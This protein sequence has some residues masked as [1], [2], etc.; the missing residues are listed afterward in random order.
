MNNEKTF[1]DIVD[2]TL[3]WMNNQQIYRE[4]YNDLKA[5]AIQKII[6]RR[7][8]ER[9]KFLWPNLN[10]YHPADNSYKPDLFT[11]VYNKGIEIKTTF[12][13]PEYRYTKNGRIKKSDD[14]NVI[15]TNS[16]TQE[17]NEYFLFITEYNGSYYICGAFQGRFIIKDDC[18]YQQA[19]KDVKLADYKP[20]S[21]EEFSKSLTPKQ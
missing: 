5:G 19:T 3:N 12:G 1:K 8:I 16:T 4:D 11:D 15:W 9:F 20:L 17:T 21:T 2:H 18:V 10:I 6:E 7:I 13:W 14:G